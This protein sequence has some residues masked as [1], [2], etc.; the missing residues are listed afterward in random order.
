MISQLTQNLSVGD[1][2]SV[3]ALETP[4]QY[5]SIITLGYYDKFDYALP[6]QSSTGDALVFPDGAHDYEVFATAVNQ[7]L[8]DIDAGNRVLVHCQAGCSR[9]PSVCIAVLGHTHDLS[10]EAAYARVKDAHPSTN[11]SPELEASARR[12]LTE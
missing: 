2:Q 11:P 6:E 4:L 3:R 12:Y 8:A 5:D 10:Y 9:S 7:T 1:C